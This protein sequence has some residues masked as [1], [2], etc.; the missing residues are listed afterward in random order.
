MSVYRIESISEDLKRT[1]AKVE[2]QAHLLKQKD[3][4][5]QVSIRVQGDL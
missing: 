5:I 3:V 2:Q 1:T 4:A